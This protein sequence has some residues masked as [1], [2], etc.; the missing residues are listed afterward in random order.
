MSKKLVI[1]TGASRGLGYELAR[2]SLSAQA[3]VVTLE[4][5]PSTGLSDFAKENGFELIQLT[6]DLTD[7][8]SAVS[9]LSWYLRQADPADYDS[10]TLINN[11]GVLGP[12]GCIC[13]ADP[14]DIDNCIRINFEV[15]ALFMSTFMRLTANWKAGKKIMNISSGAARKDVPG[16]AMYCST[17]AALDRLSST[18]AEDAKVNGLPLRIASVAPGVVDTGMQAQVRGSE[19]KDF[20]QL[21]RFIEMKEKNLLTS[22][23]D[24]AQKLLA[25]LN[26]PEFGNEVITDI[27]NINI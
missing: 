19:Q 5:K 25:F 13:R 18:V 23:Q 21:N 27:R 2:Q 9:T 4:R 12:I 20:P 8:N 17:K 10:L 11:A 3:T 7:L 22:P 14:H 15:P 26:S 16:W 24:C 6:V 1:V